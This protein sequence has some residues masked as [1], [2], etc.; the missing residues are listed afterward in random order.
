MMQFKNSYHFDLDGRLCE[1]FLPTNP[2]ERCCRDE[3]E[4]SVVAAAVVVAAV[5][6][7]D[8]SWQSERC[9]RGALEGERGAP[10]RSAEER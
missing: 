4:E 3:D 10:L 8:R 2:D 7:V 9:R 1:S 6:E 5:E